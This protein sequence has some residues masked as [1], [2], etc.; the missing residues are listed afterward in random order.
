M[1]NETGVELSSPWVFYL[2]YAGKHLRDTTVQSIIRRTATNSQHS[3]ATEGGLSKDALER[4]SS[5]SFLL[6]LSLDAMYGVPQQGSTSFDISGMLILTSGTELDTFP[7]KVLSGLIGEDD[8]TLAVGDEL[9]HWAM[10]T[11]PEL[12]DRLHEGLFCFVGYDTASMPPCTS[13]EHVEDDML[14]HKEGHT[15]LAR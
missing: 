2:V 15:P 7:G 6:Q 14:V 12:F 10:N 11:D 3:I 9:P 4:D 5:K 8:A 1:G 13:A